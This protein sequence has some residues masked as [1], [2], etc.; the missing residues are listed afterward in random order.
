MSK[1]LFRQDRWY[2]TVQGKLIHVIGYEADEPE[3]PYTIAS[4]DGNQYFCHPLGRNLGF[5]PWQTL[6]LWSHHRAR[7]FFCF[8]RS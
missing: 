5:S 2:R 7:K 8:G 6:R 3:T 4:F 1:A